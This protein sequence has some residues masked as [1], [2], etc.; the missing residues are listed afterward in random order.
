MFNNI[1]L[2]HSYDNTYERT[3]YTFL[4]YCK[5]IKYFSFAMQEQRLTL[6]KI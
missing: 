4:N 1:Q 6:M 3:E 2:K 5:L